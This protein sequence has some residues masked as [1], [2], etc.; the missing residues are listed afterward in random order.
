MSTRSKRFSIVALI[1][2]LIFALT[3]LL[4]GRM[5]LGVSA[6]ELTDNTGGGY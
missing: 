1:L 4:A 2:G 5:L 6:A 3:G